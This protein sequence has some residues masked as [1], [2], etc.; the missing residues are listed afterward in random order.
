[1]N[2]TNAHKNTH[3]QN[4]FRHYPRLQKCL[5]GLV[6]LLAT[7]LLLA[8]GYWIQQQSP[9]NNGQKTPSRLPHS[10]SIHPH[11]ITTHQLTLQLNEDDHYVG[12]GSINGVYI[13]FL[14]DTGATQVAIPS[15]LANQLGLIYGHAQ[16]V[17]TAN[18][19]TQVYATELKTLTIGNIELHD[20]PAFITS[21]LPNN[22]V[23]LGMSVLKTLD[24]RQQNQQ[25]TLIQQKPSHPTELIPDTHPP[26]FCPDC[27]PDA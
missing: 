18:G 21:Q 13:Q 4:L 5:Q 12:D 26:R 16:S 14:L 19:E 2:S 8:C 7:P 1:M 3:W 9:P 17:Q 23:L 24:L 22:E 10:S 11:I 25:L 20:I 6:F 27:R 15:P